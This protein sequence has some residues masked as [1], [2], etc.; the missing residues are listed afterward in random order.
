MTP[1]KILIVDD[2]EVIRNLLLDTLSPDG[3]SVE[4]ASN[5]EEALEKIKK[6]MFTLIITDLRMPGGLEGLELLKTIRSMNIDSEVM[7]I[8]GYG[9][10]DSVVEAMKNGAIDYIEKPFK[11]PEFRNLVAQVL[12]QRKFRNAAEK[13]TLLNYVLTI[14]QFDDNR[15]D[16]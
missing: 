12:E 1:P 8:T 3:Y 10:P 14:A 5:A 2:D 7:I 11:L 15:K 6:E 13:D 4:S 16:G 9:T